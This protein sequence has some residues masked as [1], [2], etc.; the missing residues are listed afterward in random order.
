MNN[1]IKRAIAYVK[2]NMQPYEL[3]AIDAQIDEAYE[4]HLLPENVCEY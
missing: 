4:R 2:E 1:N 3:A